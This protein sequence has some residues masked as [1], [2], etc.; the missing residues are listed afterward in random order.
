MKNKEFLYE[1]INN[2]KSI[3][4]FKNWKLNLFISLLFYRFI[5]SLILKK[6]YS[7]IFIILKSILI[8]CCTKNMIKKCKHNTNCKSLKKYYAYPREK[9]FQ[10]LCFKYLFYKSTIWSIFIFLTWSHHQSSF[11]SIKWINT[12]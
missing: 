6:H 3:I 2:H 5:Y 11:Y 12:K 9:S 7:N 10:T 4:S 8:F 1:A